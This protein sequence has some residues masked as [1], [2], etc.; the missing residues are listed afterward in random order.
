MQGRGERINVTET[1]D[2]VQLSHSE[3]VINSEFVEE[4]LQGTLKNGEDFSSQRQRKYS[5]W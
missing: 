3:G 1:L 2:N 4:D 5:R